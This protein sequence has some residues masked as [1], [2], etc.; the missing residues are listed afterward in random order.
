MSYEEQDGW[1]AVTAEEQELIEEARAVGPDAARQLRDLLRFARKEGTDA[2]VA[3][4]LA[5]T[6]YPLENRE[7]RSCVWQMVLALARTAREWGRALE[8]AG[9]L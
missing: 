7:A 4:V 5:E 1:A 8:Y 6:L 2:G 3:D 9:R